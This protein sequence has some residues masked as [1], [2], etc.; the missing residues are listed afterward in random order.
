M[1][2]K[3]Y[4]CSDDLIEV[5]GDTNGEISF[6]S[7]GGS[8][9]LLACS[10]GTILKIKYGKNVEGNEL[11]IWEIIP[12]VQGSLFDKIEFCFV[13]DADVYSDIVHFRDGLQWV[14]ATN[15]WSYVK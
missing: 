8:Y 14:I 12:L 1:S 2:T 7:K 9:A 11:G 15:K 10:D 6:L 13:D 5:E 3:I 4:G